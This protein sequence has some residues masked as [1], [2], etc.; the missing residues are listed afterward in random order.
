L[1]PDSA[2]AEQVGKTV[3]AIDHPSSF[4]AAKKA[5]PFPG[6]TADS[7][8][9]TYPASI[10]RVKVVYPEVKAETVRKP[11]PVVPISYAERL[12]EGVMPNHTSLLPGRIRIRIR[13]YPC[14]PCFT[15]SPI[16]RT[17]PVTTLVIES[18]A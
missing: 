5:D 3:K 14:C 17:R 6:A 9:Y 10:A 8:P 12:G 13:H 7:I 18:L 2:S 15:N 16:Q 4:T 11:E 1:K